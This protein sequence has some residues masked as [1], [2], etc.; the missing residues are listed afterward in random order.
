MASVLV[1]HAG[2]RGSNNG[3]VK[4]NTLKY[5]IHIKR[6]GYSVRNTTILFSVDL[7]SQVKM[8]NFG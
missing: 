6:Y 1:S 3:R 2:D 8:A 5:N 7:E 4:P